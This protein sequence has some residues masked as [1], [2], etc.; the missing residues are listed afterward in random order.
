MYTDLK[1]YL[2]TV[3]PGTHTVS[4]FT[5]DPYHP[6]R[7]TLI[8][9]PADTLGEFP[10]SVAYSALINQGIISTIERGRI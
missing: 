9:T 4:M 5:I 3:N 1:Q 6:T 8:G 7:L 10:I 2:F